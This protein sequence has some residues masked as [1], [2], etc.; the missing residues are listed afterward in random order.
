LIVAFFV[1][2]LQGCGNRKWLSAYILVHFLFPVLSIEPVA[3]VVLSSSYPAVGVDFQIRTP[4]SS[5]CMGV[6]DYCGGI[7]GGAL[8]PMDC[9]LLNSTVYRFGGPN[10]SIIYNTW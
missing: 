4:S 6:T 7:A 2:S 5:G 1:G 9:G 3:N 8:T 10:I